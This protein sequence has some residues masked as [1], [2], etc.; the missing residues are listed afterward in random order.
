MINLLNFSHDRTVPFKQSCDKLRDVIDSFVDQ[1]VLECF[2]KYFTD[3]YMLPEQVI[4]QQ[5]KSYL[6]SSYDYKKCS[7]FEKLSLKRFFI[8]V[9][10]YT[11]FLLYICAKSKKY[12]NDIKRYDLI[13]E[14]VESDNEIRLFSKL[15]ELFK[16]VLIINVNDISG[17]K[18]KTDFHPKYKQ[19]DRNRSISVLHKEIIKGLFLYFKL[20]LKCRINF[21]PIAIHIIN[22]YLYYYSI[23]KC[24]RSKYC[25]QL[26]H[27]QSSAIK[28]Y[29]FRK[30]GGV[31]SSYIQ[32]NIY[33][34]GHN[35]FYY[36]IDVF[37]TLGRKTSD[38]AF[39]YGANIKNVVPVGSLLMEYYWFTEVNGKKIGKKNYDIIFIG[40]NASTG[41]YYLDTYSSF[42]DDYYTS[43]QWLA[44]F[45]K[46]NPHVKI[47]I[48]HH[49][50][51]KRDEREMEIIN[52]T[53]IERID[54]K[55]N[56]YE[57]CFHSKCVVTYGSTMG[58]ELKAHG[59]PTLFFDPGGRCPLLPFP[60][61]PLL[62]PYRI[63]NYKEFCDKAIKLLSGQSLNGEVSTANDLCLNSREVSNNIYSWLNSKGN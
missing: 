23:F 25:I 58:Y 39:E 54:Q 63:F 45:S 31:Y 8:T 26:R 62:S 18:Y 1:P 30:S 44:D 7:F 21:I 33:Q 49:S 57:V 15:I 50:S 24:N 46:E 47:G 11:A 10:K 48:K 16:N 4:K 52:N 9:F 28:N 17:L 12:T 37:F 53:S 56:S 19:Y 60:D 20:S 38:M 42:I 35:G 51:N 43:F 34:L 22:Q 32:K 55:L 61:D 36:D 59:L 40:I 13:V 3:H 29:L 5:L 27:Y 41:F 2:Y 6:A 14:W